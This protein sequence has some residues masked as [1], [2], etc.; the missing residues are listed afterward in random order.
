VCACVRVHECIWLDKLVTS[1]VPE[2]CCLGPR[3]STT[4]SQGICGY[5]SVMAAWKFDVLVKIIV[6]LF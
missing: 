1:L 4:S 3:G 2:V 6:E 5:I